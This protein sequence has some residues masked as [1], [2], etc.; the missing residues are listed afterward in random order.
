MIRPGL[1]LKEILR[2]RGIETDACMASCDLPTIVKTRVVARSQQVCRIDREVDPAEQSADLTGKFC[3]HFD[4][5]IARTDAI[6]VSDYAK[7]TITQSLYDHIIGLGR[8]YNKLVA[9][10]PKP[11]RHLNLQTAG[12]LTPNW[13]EALQLA[14]VKRIASIQ[15]PC[16]RKDLRENLF[17]VHAIP[18]AGNAWCTRNGSLCRRA[19]RGHL[20]R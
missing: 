16:A 6:I 14:G 10:D 1:Q 7:G 11:T 4:A 2:N 5:T 9:V 13:S 18:S 20:S 8:R 15:C 3:E 12:L 17:A 19:R